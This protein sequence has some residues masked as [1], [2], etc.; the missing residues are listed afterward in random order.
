MEKGVN[1]NP[2]VKPVSRTL[3]KSCAVWN[4]GMDMPLSTNHYQKI[5]THFVTLLGGECVVCGSTF[6]LEIHHKV[7]SKMGESR[8]RDRRA[9][10]WFE[11]Y[12]NNNIS[13][14][15]HNCHTKV[16]QK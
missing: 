8:G 9:W 5:R 3:C 1:M 2:T 6:N 15:C 4:E 13:L 11:E 14:L 7:D 16:H 12:E 10:N